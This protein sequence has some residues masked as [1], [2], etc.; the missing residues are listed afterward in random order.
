LAA[1]TDFFISC[2]CPQSLQVLQATAMWTLHALHF[3]NM[4]PGILWLK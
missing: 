1:F 3:L 2:F 4:D